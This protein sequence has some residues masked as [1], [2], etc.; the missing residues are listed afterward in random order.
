MDLRTARGQVS[1]VQVAEYL[2][3]TYNKSKGEIRPQYEHPNGDKVIICNPNDNNRQIYFNRDGSNDKGSILDFIKNRLSD[4]KNISYQ[5]GMDGVT[6]VLKQFTNEP[7]T[8]TPD[9][10]RHDAERIHQY[11]ASKIEKP[12]FDISQFSVTNS[13]S[14][15][16]LEYLSKRGI[17]NK[18]LKAFQ[19]HIALV[20]DNQGNTPTNIGFPYKN[21]KGEVTGFELRNNDF[22]GHARGT[23]KESSVWAANFAMRKEMTRKVFLFESAIDAMSFYQLFNKQY[24]F[25]HA[26]F[27]SFG[28]SLA[29][30]Q[31]DMVTK[32]YLNARFF[33]GF[34]NDYNGNMFDIMFEKRLNPNFEVE[35]KR[36][37]NQI[38][39]LHKDVE[40]RFEK[41]AISLKAISESAN[42]KPMLYVIKPKG[43]HKDYN[44]ELWSLTEQI[45][46]AEKKNI[47]LSK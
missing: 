6:Q 37:E 47:K 44:D 9:A 31:I 7:N 24:D 32:S 5:K 23:D 1:I 30:K 43:L 12:Q 35:F 4:F 33:S 17:N 21:D 2:G 25:K 22:K 19:K 16:Q 36:E 38:V 15:N 26:A 28:G 34:D 40:H 27:I 29:P 11:Q 14:L 46:Q 13:P 45:K 3:Y 10:K 8:A 20:K 41:D 39:A 42:L 18:T